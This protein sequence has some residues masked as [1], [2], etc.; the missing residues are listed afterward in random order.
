V[1]DVAC[2]TGFLTRRLGAER[3]AFLAEARR[4][5]REL[6]VVDAALRP[7]GD[8]EAWQARMLGDGS[9]HRVYKRWF[10]PE[11]LAAELGRRVSVLHAGA[12]FV[13]VASGQT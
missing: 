11:G 12:W 7:G 8:A 1:L 5:A 6:V 3:D 4:V 9:Y 13:V 10:T 2:G